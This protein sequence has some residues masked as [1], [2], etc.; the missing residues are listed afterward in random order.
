MTSRSWS[1][2]AGAAILLL[3]L[4]APSFAQQKSI[5]AL[6]KEIEALNEKMKVMQKDLQEI[7]ALLQ[8]RGPAPA[9]Q[10]VVLELGDAP[11]RGSTRARL[12]LVEFSDYQCSFCGSFTKDTYPQ[13][14]KEYVETGKIRYLTMSLP[15]ESIHKSAFKAAEAA[16]CAGEQGKFWEMHVRLFASQATLDQWKT[17][18]EVVGLDVP[19][20]QA[21][22]DGGRQAA[23]IRSDMAQAQRAGLTGTPAF[24][25]AYTEP[26]STKVTTVT[27]M[28]GAQP[29]AAFKA[30]FD[31]MLAEKPDVAK[32]S[33]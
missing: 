12:T 31:R 18:A 7:K 29:Y 10:N 1:L 20:F 30:T 4:A 13:I 16:A 5:E 2:S 33:R 15:L 17:H 27:K 23:K 11:S 32:A 3:F 9:P 19:K 22:L 25:L 28:V 21:C 8:V 24:F 26:N 14:D 6:R